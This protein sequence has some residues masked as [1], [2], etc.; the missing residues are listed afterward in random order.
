MMFRTIAALIGLSLVG[1]PVGAQGLDDAALEQAIK[2][3]LDN[4]F[5]Q[6]SAQCKAGVSLS[7]KRKERAA[8]WT[9][10]SVHFTGA[11]QVT[12][13]TSSGRVAF[14]AAEAKRQRTSFTVSDVPDQLRTDALYVVVDPIKPGG[15]WGSGVEVPSPIKGII[16]R[17]KSVPASQV[18][19]MS[20]EVG[21]V[22]WTE[23]RTIM[24]KSRPGGGFDKNLFE[25]SRAT[26]TMPVESA[27][28]LPA[29]DLEIVVVTSGADRRCD[30]TTKERLRLLP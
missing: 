3:G 4:K 24:M 8:S 11:Y 30:S 15:D 5:G 2:A 20:L 25:Q 17:S 29:G 23:G 6:W 26:A 28:A 27:R 10:D 9:R 14:L 21:D 19:P 22:Q 1:V 7:D 13:L 18:E 16:L 12:V